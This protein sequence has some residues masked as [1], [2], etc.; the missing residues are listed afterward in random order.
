MFCRKL[1]ENCRRKRTEG[2]ALLDPRIDQVAHLRSPRVGEDGASAERARTELHAPV[3]PADHL[4][5]LEAI[6]RRFEKRRLVSAKILLMGVA[7][8][9]K[10]RDLVRLEPGADEDMRQP[11]PAQA[12]YRSA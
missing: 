5:S 10:E 11:L 8:G 1:L 2:L 4:A 3:K 7:V 9:K 12:V 6:D